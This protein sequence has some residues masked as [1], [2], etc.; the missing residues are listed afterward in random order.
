MTCKSYLQHNSIT[1]SLVPVVHQVTLRQIKTWVE[2]GS[3]SPRHK[4]QQCR[5]K[6]L[7]PE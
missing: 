5:L 7:P 1:V 2:R 4:A 3:G 6:E